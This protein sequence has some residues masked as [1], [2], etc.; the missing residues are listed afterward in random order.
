MMVKLED[1]LAAMRIIESPA[2]A[3]ATSE[4]LRRRLARAENRLRGIANQIVETEMP[5]ESRRQLM[6]FLESAHD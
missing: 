5:D 6:T 4:V 2:E 1:A 3:V